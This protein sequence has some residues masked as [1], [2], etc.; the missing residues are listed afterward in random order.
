MSSY[1]YYLVPQLSHLIYGQA[2]P[3]SSE[4]FRAMAMPLLSDEDASL[5]DIL[6]LDPQP[7]D[8]NIPGPS[9]A[10]QFTPSGSDF[11]DGWREW[12]RA[13]R[14]NLAKQRFSRL[15]RQGDTGL[16]EPP[17]SPVDAV[18]TAAK[19][20][21]ETPYEGEITIDKARWS[22]IEA[23]QG[24]DYFYRNTIFAYFLKLLILERYALFKT[25]TGFSEYKLLYTS[26]LESANTGASPTG[27]PS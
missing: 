4:E 1:Y 23:L 27:E 10:E 24:N 12:E 19:A 8:S 21:N 20:V 3:I 13:L 15:K 14:L 7:H 6:G 9:Y 2:P 22:A 17:T 18:A 5:L 11:I 25:E 16:A 26:I